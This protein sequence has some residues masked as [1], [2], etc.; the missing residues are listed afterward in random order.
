MA[1]I[2]KFGR[3]APP[4]STVLALPRL[5]GDR[6]QATKAAVRERCRFLHL[7]PAQTAECVDHAA[8]LMRR[9]RSGAVATAAGIRLAKDIAT[10]RDSWQPGGA[11]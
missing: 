8:A 3:V 6:Y 11:A 1:A 10:Q 4:P 7:T 9:G 2:L 5:R